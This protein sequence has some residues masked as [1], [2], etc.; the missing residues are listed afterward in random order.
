MQLQ[1]LQAFTQW[2]VDG[3]SPPVSH[4]NPLQERAKSVWRDLLPD[5]AS[6]MCCC[7]KAV[8]HMA[9]DSGKGLSLNIK[10]EA[11]RANVMGCVG[12]SLL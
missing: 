2:D 9:Q 11:A 5:Q 4:S 10:H 6:P 3:S 8:A 12:T 7:C 1:G